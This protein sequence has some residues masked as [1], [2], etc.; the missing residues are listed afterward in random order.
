MKFPPFYIRKAWKMYLFSEEPTIGHGHYPSGLIF[1]QAFATPGGIKTHKNVRCARTKPSKCLRTLI[2][3]SLPFKCLP[4]QLPLWNSPLSVDIHSPRYVPCSPFE[5]TTETSTWNLVPGCKRSWIGTSF[6]CRFMWIIRSGVNTLAKFNFIYAN[7]VKTIM[8]LFSFYTHT[9]GV[10]RSN[11]WSLQTMSRKI[12]V[13]RQEQKQGCWEERID[14][15]LRLWIPE[16]LKP[17][18]C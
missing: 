17:L 7:N 14:L 5:V 2:P 18:A 16:G 9:A 8:T 10:L 3:L 1:R 11:N 6:V 12:I 4:S 15:S 13:E